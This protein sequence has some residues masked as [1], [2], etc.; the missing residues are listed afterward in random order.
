[1]D[2]CTRAVSNATA[3]LAGSPETASVGN[4][5]VSVADVVCSEQDVGKQRTVVQSCSA[6]DCPIG[7]LVQLYSALLSV[8]VEEEDMY[9][10]PTHTHHV[11]CT[12]APPPPP[13][14]HTHT[15]DLPIAEAMI[16]HSYVRH[17]N[18]CWEY[19]IQ[20]LAR[21]MN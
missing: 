3:G 12:M 4:G 10:P 18:L 16:A 2:T 20:Q 15:S 13:P 9:S 1:M 8:T 19:T 11:P 6:G 7:K 17:S 21:L 5:S 14:P